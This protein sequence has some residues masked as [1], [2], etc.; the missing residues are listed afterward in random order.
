MKE[1]KNSNTERKT[2]KTFGSGTECRSA[3][4]WQSWTY[5]NWNGFVRWSSNARMI[6]SLIHSTYTTTN[7][8]ITI[9]HNGRLFVQRNSI[10]YNTHLQTSGL[11][12]NYNQCQRY[13]CLSAV[14]EMVWTWHGMA[15]R[16][17]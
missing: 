7:I 14:A 17:M 10:Q 5:L 1:L 2:K 11:D 16:S 9:S 15:E 6:F 12:P 4:L 8:N 13:H 3:R